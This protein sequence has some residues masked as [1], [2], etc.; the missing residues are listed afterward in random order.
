MRVCDTMFS[1]SY[2]LPGSVFRKKAT[3]RAY[4]S[5]TAEHCITFP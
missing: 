1:H 3:A 4:I 5:N 2:G